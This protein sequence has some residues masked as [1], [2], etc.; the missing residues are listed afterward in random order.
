MNTI[1]Q[2][3]EIDALRGMNDPANN[4]KREMSYLISKLPMSEQHILRSSGAKSCSKIFSK[5]AL[6][7]M[8][9]MY[10]SVCENLD[11][12]IKESFLNE[13]CPSAVNPSSCVVPLFAAKFER[14][15]SRFENAEKRLEKLRSNCTLKWN[16]IFAKESQSTQVN[17]DESS[18]ETT[19]VEVS[20]TAV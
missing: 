7:D 10:P 16:R 4:L 5:R 20:T 17:E 2:S 18:D 3:A 13:K 8:T 19:A 12:T 11:A 6:R 1:E 9:V 14:E 15:K